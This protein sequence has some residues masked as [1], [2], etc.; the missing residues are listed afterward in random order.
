MDG[1]EPAL[2]E[3]V[4]YRGGHLVRYARLL[5]GDQAEAEDLV[6]EALVH[7][8]AATRRPKDDRRGDS[9]TLENAEAYVRRTVLNLFLDGY[10]RRQRWVAVRHLLGGQGSTA[11]PERALPDQLDLAAA[12]ATLP[13]RQRACVVLRYYEDLSVGQIAEYLGVTAG[14]VKRHLHDANSALAVR[15]APAVGGEP[16]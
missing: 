15:L 5:C 4:R 3:L 10:R 16:A 14:T 7:V 9:R 1:W 12:L 11:G 6:Q 8:F 13:P 2:T